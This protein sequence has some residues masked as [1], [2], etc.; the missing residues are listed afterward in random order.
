[1]SHIHISAG[2]MAKCDL[3]GKGKGEIPI[4]E[5]KTGKQRWICERC[6]LDLFDA[7]TFRDKLHKEIKTLIKLH[8][9]EGNIYAVNSLKYLMS[10]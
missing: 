1:L 8:K 3:C 4:T 5:E 2:K 10:L 9:K 7:R 6:D